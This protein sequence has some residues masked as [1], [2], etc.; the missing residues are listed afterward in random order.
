MKKLFAMAALAAAAVSVSAGV[1]PRTPVVPWG[2][3]SEIIITNDLTQQNSD[4]SWS[5]TADAM[6]WVEYSYDGSTEKGTIQ[7][8]NRPNVW[9]DFYSETTTTY[10]AYGEVAED[11]T[12]DMMFEWDGWD[13]NATKKSDQPFPG[14]A[15]VLNESTG[16]PYGDPSVNAFADLSG[17]L[18][19]EVTCTEGAPRILMNRDVTEGQWNENEAESHLID[20]TKG[21]WSSK[22]FSQEGDK[23]IVDLQKLVQDKGYAHLHAIKGANW[24]NCTVTKM[25]LFSVGTDIVDKEVS[26]DEMIIGSAAS[27]WGGY[28]TVTSKTG[29]TSGLMVVGKSRYPAFFVTGT[30]KAKFYFSGS[31]SKAGYAQ[32]EVYEVGSDVPVATKTGDIAL[33][34]STWDKSTLLIA[35]GLDKSKSYKIVCR[36]MNMLEDKTFGY[37]GGDIVLQVVKIYGDQAP[38][39]ADGLIISGSEIGN[40]INAHLAAY[41]DVKDFTLEGNGKYT[42]TE[43]IVANSNV[44]LTGV[45]S[46]PATIDASALAAP[47]VQLAEIAED[48]E[49]DANGFVAINNVIFENVKIN[50]LAQP[51]FSSNKQNYL[52][53][54]VAIKNSVIELA[55]NPFV[56]DFRNGGVAAKVGVSNSTIWA[57]TATGN[58]F[59]TSQ[60][61][62]KATEA[63]LEEQVFSFTNSTLSNIASGKNFFTHRQSGQTWLTFEVKN[64]II[65]NCG[66]DNFLASLNQ[67][68]AS[69][70]PKYSVENNTILKTAKEGEGDEAIDVLSN[71]NDAQAT[72]DEAEE[73]VNPVAGVPFTLANALAGKFTVTAS[74]Q[75]AKNMIGDPRWLVPYATDAIK[76]EV[77][78]SENTDFIAAIN[79]ALEQSE[80]PSSIEVSFW[81]AGEYPTTAE[82]NTTAPV[83]FLNG[84]D[85]DAGAATIVVK[86]GM[87]LGGSIEFNGVNIDATDLNAPVITLAGNEYKMQSNG[88]YNMGAIKFLN[89]N[90]KGVAQQL[91]YGNKVKNQISELLV[92]NSV[93]KLVGSNKVAFDFNG[94]GA[95]GA[96]NIKKSTIFADPAS[97]ASLFSTQSGNKATEA[98]FTTQN[99]AIDN[100]TL[101]N[102]AVGKNFYTH[103]QAN[104]TWIAYYLRNNIFMNVGKSGQVVK[105]INQGQSGKNPKWTV[106]GN[107]FL[108]ANE[109]GELKDTSADE[110]TGDSDEPVQ[111]SIA[112]NGAT[113]AGLADGNFNGTLFTENPISANPGDPRWTIELTFKPTTAKYIYNAF[114]G[115]FLSRGDSW[116]TR[117]VGDDY[118]LPFNVTEADGKYT[119]NLIDWEGT[120]YGDDYWMYAD[121]SGDRARSYYL[122]ATTG[123][124]FLRNANRPVEDNRMYIY[125]K[126]DAD[127]YA[128]AGNA[129]VGDGEDANCADEAQ[130]V[131]QFLSQEERDAIVKEKD[132]LENASAMIAAGYEAADIDELEPGEEKQLTFKTGSAWQFTPKRNGSN[133]VT[134]EFGTEIYQGTGS[135]TQTVEGLEPGLYLVGMQGFYRDGWNEKVAEL[136]K[137][138]Y[139]LST[140]YIDANGN[141]AQI[142]SWGAAYTE[143]TDAEGK[144]I[145]KPNSMA[146]AAESFAADNYGCG[147]M[148][149]VGEDGK[150]NLTVCV[151]T[152]NNGGWFIAD[153]VTY[154]KLDKKADAPAGDVTYAL[155][156]GDTFTSG[157][158]VEVKP[159]EEVVATIQYGEEGGND[160]NAAV[161][162]EHASEWGY[163][164]STG[165]NGTNGNKPGGTFYTIVPK[166]DGVIAAAIVLNADKKFH[167]TVD[168]EQNPVFDNNTVSEKYYGPV[169][170][171]VEAGKAYKFY[172]DGSKLGFYGF[173]Y[174]YGPDVEPITEVS[175]A[176]QIVTVGIENVQTTT[177]NAAIYNLNGQKVSTLQKGQL[178]I[179]NG[180]KFIVK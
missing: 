81:E 176:E 98:G 48:A 100:S 161:A 4:G 142:L 26:C 95:I 111:N 117:A 73:I 121:C 84:S 3:Q 133:A 34:K 160:F 87:T 32:I 51:L 27:N 40:Y 124:F 18:R 13:Q 91:V 113:F 80:Q 131:W 127:K 129:I 155:V 43:G 151:P 125:L 88:F 170:F 168:G 11:L 53:P 118:G 49:K 104:Q 148:T 1:T 60:S 30:D 165:G 56:L 24:A 137:K 6:Q 41:P 109:N 54:E 37:E 146:E 126:D 150:L 10:K 47:F 28:F 177:A 45:A 132:L 58:S 102:I 5:L 134:N 143:S 167:L 106:N 66:K 140:S 123:G 99:F 79:A 89:M 61:G 116:G 93:I 50:A 57:A 9:F 162:D 103:R 38:M 139:N 65:A 83:R 179:Q 107:V 17:Y 46:A 105:G 172:C 7:Q 147:V 156:E 136:Y 8:T 110:S 72:S 22:Y 153:N 76:I 92:E 2:A 138:G 112:T 159:N 178:Y 33:T 130:T 158:I 135:F 85:I 31:A 78:K 62:K 163:T 77:D 175:I 14:C 122:E 25:E 67:G 108:Y 52:I 141:R 94:G 39:R 164:A 59:Y 169:Q 152:F 64:N 74:S 70:N 97:E 96:F 35:D 42:I 171:N 166:Y 69:A 101:Y 144:V 75:Q 29:S 20:N 68:Q 120:C 71:I 149:Y 157:Q 23:W 90:V 128:I 154:A 86:N 180:K 12:K 19:L 55:G 15:Y 36:T 21:G 44:T 114:S 63:G 119:L 145:Y 173:N 174:K 82:L 115:K 16:Q